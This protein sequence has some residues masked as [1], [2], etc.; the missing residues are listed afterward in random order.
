[1]F[2]RW[3][4]YFVNLYRFSTEG[5]PFAL[6]SSGLLQMLMGGS[7]KHWVPVSDL[8]KEVEIS[9]MYNNKL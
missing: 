7:F 2:V 5:T 3:L 4:L 1:M 8:R 6:D 9:V